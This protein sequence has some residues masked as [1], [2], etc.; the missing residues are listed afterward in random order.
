[1][2]RFFTSALFFQTQLHT[3]RHLRIF[4][5]LLFLGAVFISNTRA[6]GSCENLLPNPGFEEH[7]REF[8]E[9]GSG[10]EWSNVK[11]WNNVNLQ[12]LN[13]GY[14]YFHDDHPNNFAGLP[15][16]AFGL[17]YAHGGKAVIGLNGWQ[18]KFPDYRIYLS[19]EMIHPM[20]PGRMY[21]VSFWI[22]NGQ[23]NWGGYGIDGIGICFSEK[24]LKQNFDELID[25]TP[26]WMSP[27]IIFDTAWRQMT[28]QFFADKAYQYF[29]IG[30]FLPAAEMSYAEFAPNT[31]TK[32][33]LAFYFVD[34]FSVTHYD[35]GFTFSIAGD[36]V[37]CPGVP[38][39][40]HVP[41]SGQQDY[42]WSTGESGASIEVTAGGIYSATV[43]NVCGTFSDSIEVT[44]G[45]VKPVIPNSFTP[46]GDQVNDVFRILHD[47]KI[48]T[49]SLQIYN[50]W[51]SLI[52]DASPGNFFWDGTVQGRP[53]PSDV[54]VYLLEYQA[55]GENA[56][57][58]VKGDVTLLR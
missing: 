34:D 46:N 10:G 17:V 56:P 28:F 25:A 30:N 49:R 40:L 9:T 13:P 4:I 6:Q 58:R 47:P 41:L 39:T 33:P 23:K 55:A 19:A 52:F 20:V 18:K 1:M 27:G 14:H 37:V 21:D 43:T 3:C 22:T 53:A 26:Q 32:G 7:Y 42:H 2:K 5:S 11:E 8:T 24:P 36:T 29:T 51:G 54:Y 15:N 12:P 50:R 57:S 16:T 35:P 45:C 31:S 38:A 44:K 48:E